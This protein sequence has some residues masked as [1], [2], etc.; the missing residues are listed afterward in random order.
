MTV[1]ASGPLVGALVSPGKKKQGLSV[2][3]L[4]I[5]GTAEDDSALAAVDPN[6]R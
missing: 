2:A 4:G 1:E 6:L 5:I 3:P